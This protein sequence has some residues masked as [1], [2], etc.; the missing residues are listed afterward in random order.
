MTT[1]NNSASSYPYLFQPVVLSETLALP[2][3]VVMAPLT[4]CF[5]GPGLV[6][7]EQMADYYAK[8]AGAGLIVSE[9]T[10]ISPEA[11]GYP[12]TPG[13]Y[14][15]EQIAGWK[16]ATDKVHAHGG[17]MFNQ[18]WHLGRVAHSHYTGSQPLAPSAI[19][20]H[21]RVPRSP[22]LEYEQPRAMSTDEVRHMVERYAQAAKNAMQAGFD[23]VEIHGANG[24]LIDQF[25]RQQ[26]NQRDDEYGGSLENRARFA[27][28]VVDAVTAAVG[29]DRVGIRLSPN[30][31]VHL[32]HT[33]GDEE[34]FAWLLHELGSR[35]MAYVHEG[36]FD[37]HIEY[38]YLGGRPSAFLRQHYPGH[39]IA[40]GSLTP[41]EA[42]RMIQAGQSDLVAIGRPFI[43][44]P[45]L[46]DKLRTGETPE[47]FD[48]EMLKTL[49]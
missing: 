15:P 3:S 2:N 44:N 49:V 29:A 38:D 12:N 10:I 42:N 26:T 41:E 32:E 28:E 25:L 30:A 19:G 31:H 34:T 14:T 5:A 9:A 1:T 37:D 35:D 17:R 48:P 40:C 39:V 18:L 13:I 43:A 22:G 27:L 7:T 11:Q 24:Y 21:G 46:M 45:D 47:P 20:W 36:A 8:R 23:G 16:M 4:R 6:P 33:P